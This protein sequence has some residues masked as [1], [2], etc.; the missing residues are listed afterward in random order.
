[1]LSTSRWSGS[2]PGRGCDTG[3]LAASAHRRMAGRRESET[4]QPKYRCNQSFGLAQRQA[5]DRPPRQRGR[6]RQGRVAGLAAARAAGLGLHAAI[7]V[8][9]N[10]TVRLPRW[11]K[12]LS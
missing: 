1:V 3:N 12:A 6:D 9:V 7:A 8:S 4:K 10:H 5:E 2:L 11:R